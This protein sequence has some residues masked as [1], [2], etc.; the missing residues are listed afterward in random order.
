M[1][2]IQEVNAV[3]TFFY[4]IIRNSFYGEPDE[5]YFK[6]IKDF[7]ENIKN[8]NDFDNEKLAFLINSF[9]SVFNKYKFNDLKEEYYALFV[10]P[11]SDNLVN[12]NA[13]HYFENK[14]FGKTLAEVRE[15]IWNLKVTK[16]ESFKEPEDS[17][18]FM[19]DFMIYLINDEE[20][21][22]NLETQKEFF[23]GF[24]EPLYIKFSET[25]KA[26]SK[27][28]FYA[29]IALLMD[30]FLDLEKGYLNTNNSSGGIL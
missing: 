8:N 22:D 12:K 6:M 11:F 17:I 20:N 1:K 28:V 5:T 16:D 23:K 9:E 10:D 14:N 25:L 30:Y 18:A 7:V 13:S 26:N 24:I 15:F 2:E 4:E 19:S 21:E 3:R 27:A 29:C